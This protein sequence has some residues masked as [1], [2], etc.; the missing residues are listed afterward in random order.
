MNEERSSS[1]V[2]RDGFPSSRPRHPRHEGGRFVRSPSPAIDV[3]DPSMR[4]GRSRWRGDLACRHCGSR[5]GRARPDELSTDE[6]LDLIAQMAQLGVKE[7]SLIG[8]EAYLRDDWTTLIEAIREQGMMANMTSGGRALTPERA[9]RAKEAGLQSISLSIDGDE[10]THDRLR[11][12]TGA[13]RAVRSSLANMRAAGVPVAVNSQI[14]RLSM[15]CLEHILEVLIEHQCHAWQFQLTVPMGAPPMNRMYC[16]S[17]TTCSNCFL[18]SRGLRRRRGSM[19]SGCCLETTWG[20]SGRTS[21][22]FARTCRANTALNAV[23]G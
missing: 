21:I 12:A 1:A 11:G 5:A 3:C 8:G 17:R 13:Y 16:S 7:V 9:R 18:S 14:N 20:I 22:S 6:C 23:P 4:S 15:V 2:G 10:E 19:V